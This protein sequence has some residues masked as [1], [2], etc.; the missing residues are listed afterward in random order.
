MTNG[1]PNQYTVYLN[2]TCTLK[3]AKQAAPTLQFLR[4]KIKMIF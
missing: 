1:A 3:T 2:L 4:K